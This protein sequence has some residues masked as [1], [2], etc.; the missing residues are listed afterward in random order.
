[1]NSKEKATLAEAY[2]LRHLVSRGYEVAVPFNGNSVADLVFRQ[3]ES[4]FWEGVQVKAAY[5][6]GGADGPLTANLTK[7]E[8]DGETRYSL[9][10]VLSFIIVDVET[11]ELWW[12]D[13]SL[14]AR[15]GRITLNEKWEKYRAD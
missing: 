13:A 8:S 11:A 12:I 7:R 9:R 6:R 2:A 4:P 15:Y 14:V 1:M 3:E 5:H 10:D